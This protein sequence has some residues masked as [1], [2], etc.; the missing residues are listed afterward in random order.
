[1]SRE[2]LDADGIAEKMAVLDGWT[3][4]RDGAAISK[5]FK[6]RNFSEAFAFMTRSAL[7]AEKLDHHPEWTNVYNT[8]DVVL[9]THDTGG[10]TV[11]DFDLARRMDRY[12][13]VTVK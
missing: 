11:L 2:K 8:V 4:I 6:F 10:L 12:G 1:M 9:W 7:A 5:T 3:L 13:P